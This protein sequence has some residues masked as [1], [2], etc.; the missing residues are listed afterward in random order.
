MDQ[1]QDR[2]RYGRIPMNLDALISVGG[3]PPFACTVRDFCGAGMFIAVDARELRTVNPQDR[4]TL[5]F[6]VV[7]GDERRE[8]Q[9]TLSVSRVIPS[10]LG[11]AFDDPDPATVELLQEIAGPPPLAP[12]S[13]TETQRRFAPEF[14]RVLPRMSSLVEKTAE[15]LAVEFYILR[16]YRHLL[17]ETENAALD[18]RLSGWWEGLLERMH[19]WGAHARSAT[20]APA[21]QPPALDARDAG[22]AKL[23][24]PLQ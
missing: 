12:E 13:L 2:R 14:A 24:P 7:V 3:R 5:Y 10:G 21:W 18:A 22:S 4:A 23:W 16:H 15:Q 20:V 9:L 17:T 11:V 8:L 1:G 6:A 19:E